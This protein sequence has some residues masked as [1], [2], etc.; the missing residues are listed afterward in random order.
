MGVLDDEPVEPHHPVGLLDHGEDLSLLSDLQPVT[1]ALVRG[2]M[3]D[4]V[5]PVAGAGE[6]HGIQHV[7]LVRSCR[8]KAQ[9]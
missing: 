8:P 4:V 2:G 1:Q 7:V 5:A 9:G 6:G 3:L